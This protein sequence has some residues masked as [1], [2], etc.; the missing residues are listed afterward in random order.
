MFGAVVQLEFSAVDVRDGDELFLASLGVD[1]AL[2]PL[3][4]AISCTGDDGEGLDPAFYLGEL[5]PI[6]PDVFNA[7]FVEGIVGSSDGDVV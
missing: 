1:V 3:S 7:S 5:F 4:P 2:L 6:S